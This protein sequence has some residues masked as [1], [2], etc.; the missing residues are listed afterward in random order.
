MPGM[1]FRVPGTFGAST[2]RAA[3]LG[4]LPGDVPLGARHRNVI[5]RRAGPLPMQ[6]Q[7]PAHRDAVLALVEGPRLHPRG[8]VGL[9]RALAL[10]QVL[11]PGLHDVALDHAGRVVQV[12]PDAM[13]DGAV[14]AA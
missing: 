1:T 5:S 4:W 7:V 9:G 14:T 11:R 8:A 10:A 12:V 2:T 3:V 6:Q 13:P